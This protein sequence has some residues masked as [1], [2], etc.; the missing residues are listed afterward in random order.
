MLASNIPRSQIRWSGSSEGL[1]VLDTNAL[2][3]IYRFTKDARADYIRALSLLGNRLW[4][5]HQTAQEFF[6]GR[7]T[8]IR[9][10]HTDRNHFDQEL[11]AALVAVVEAILRYDHRR[12]LDHA[13]VQAITDLVDAAQDRMLEK[14]DEVVDAGAGTDANGHPEDDPVLQQ[15]EKLINGKSGKAPELRD[16][17]ARHKEWGTRFA[18]H[19][20]LGHMDAK[21]GD[22]EIGEFLVWHQTIEESKRRRTMPVLM[23]CNEQKPDWVRHDGA[24]SSPR[25]ELVKECAIP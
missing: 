24:Y 1:V 16:L 20:P 2:L 25:H 19:T 11:S 15:I 21:K 6:E 3:D 9:S 5:P 8:V 22:R 12:G 14:L 4:V 23:I 17:A 10:W 7:T 18:A 13:D